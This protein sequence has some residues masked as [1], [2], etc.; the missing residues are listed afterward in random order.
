MKI[1]NL[2]LFITGL[3]MMQTFTSCEKTDDEEKTT[4]QV[5]DYG[6]QDDTYSIYMAL[7]YSNPQPESSTEKYY[8]ILFTS[9]NPELEIETIDVEVQGTAIDL[10]YANYGGKAFYIAYFYEEWAETYHFKTIINGEIT[11]INFDMPTQLNM[12]LPLYLPENESVALSWDLEK[13]PKTIFIE[14]FQWNY[15]R[16]E[17][18]KFTKDFLHSEVREFVM[19]SEWLWSEEEA[20]YRDIQI[21]IMNHEIKNDICFTVSDG[22]YRSYQ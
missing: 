1:L 10:E 18:L 9:E 22:I 13:Q 2:V 5:I 20:A 6:P 11:E 16:T 15:D 17:R 19:P 7:S 12:E 8:Y 21:C 4:Q 3:A 14:G